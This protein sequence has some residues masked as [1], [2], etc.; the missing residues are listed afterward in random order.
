MSFGMRPSSIRRKWP[1]QHSL[2]CLSSVYMLGRLARLRTWALSNSFAH[3]IPRMRCR[4]RMWR[5]FS[6]RSCLAYIVHASLPYRSVL[7]MH[8]SFTAIFV[9][10]VS[11]GFSQTRVVSGPNIVVAYPVRWLISASRDRLSPG[12]SLMVEPR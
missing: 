4:L 11:L 3:I 9:A 5:L 12:L 8:A 1:S 7:M 2:R 10:T 6:F